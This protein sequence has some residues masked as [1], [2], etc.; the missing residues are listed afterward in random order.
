[1]KRTAIYCR[2]STARQEKEGDSI[3][4]QLDALREYIR[5]RDDLIPA[6]EYVDA[7]ISGTKEQ[8]DELQ[9]MLDD[10]R[11]GKID[12]VIV[13]RLDRL[14]RSLRNFLNMQSVLEKNHCEWL[15][16][17]EPIYN[18]STAQGRMII[19]TFVNLAEFEAA[20]TSSRI[21]QVF[22]YKA[23]Q[24]E[25]LSGKVL[26]GYQ[27]TDKHLTIDPAA[28]P[29]V[30]ALFD[31]YAKNNSL[32]D[33]VRLAGELGRVT[34]IR[35]MKRLLKNRKYIGEYRGNP[36]YCPPI[37]E[38]AVFDA[39]QIGL[40][41]NIKQS[42]K[43]T[44]IFSGLLVCAECGRK[45]AG[46]NH[47]TRRNGKEYPLTLYR[48]NGHYS[49]M[50]HCSQSRTIS[51]TTIEN[52]VLKAVK[53]EVDKITI[54]QSKPRQKGAQRATAAKE[55]AIQRKL[56]RLKAAYLNGAIPLDEYKM[57]R[58]QLTEELTALK[59]SE[60]RQ[61]APAVRLDKVFTSDFE[62]VYKALNA[63]E[64]RRLWRSVIKEIRMDAGKN[65][66]IIF[67]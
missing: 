48:C 20:N 66:D 49:P 40:A 11:A 17:W 42:Q 32:S 2:V 21:R 18:S 26:F 47:A 13:T 38:P 51:E 9:R 22:E 8:R 59:A 25:I 41:R 7:G 29:V 36:N 65:L 28:A 43:R 57:D 64:R 33:A 58:E 50:V 16:I 15:A 56:E 23:Q 39:V 27:I 1:M 19:N 31:E 30:R 10:V 4:A 60:R 63:S 34:D 53:A 67:L 14:H 62:T 61:T 52:A 54:E 46:T 45:M 3:P 44:Y 12:L 24:G 5:Q 37:I 6:G 35:S 55:K